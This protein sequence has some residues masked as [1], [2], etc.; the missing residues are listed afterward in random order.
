M[1]TRDWVLFGLLV[2]VSVFAVLWFTRAATR[3]VRKRRLE[4]FDGPRPA[5]LAQHFGGVGPDILVR[6]LPQQS[7]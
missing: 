5:D 2:V 7:D 3:Q 6:V 4:R 1:T